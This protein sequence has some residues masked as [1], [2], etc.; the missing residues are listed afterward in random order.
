MLSSVDCLKWQQPCTPPACWTW[1]LNAERLIPAE[2]WLSYEGKSVVN[3]TCRSACWLHLVACCCD[4]ARLETQLKIVNGACD[5]QSFCWYLS[6]E[7]MVE[8]LF[9]I[10]PNYVFCAQ[11]M[12]AFESFWEQVWRQITQFTSD[13]RTVALLSETWWPF[14]FGFE[15]KEKD[16]LQ[17]PG[18]FTSMSRYRHN[19]WLK[20]SRSERKKHWISATDPIR[21]LRYR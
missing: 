8:S 18:H 16:R 14:V 5:Q 13:L 17:C 3:R 20:Y 12:H 1:C 9:V 7:L 19:T 6:S 21:Y 2:L 11:T 15:V 10:S 4:S